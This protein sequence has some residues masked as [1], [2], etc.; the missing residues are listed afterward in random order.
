MSKLTH[1]Q[2]RSLRLRINR[3]AHD[4]T[5]VAYLKERDAL[6]QKV[7]DMHAAGVSY[8]K[9]HSHLDSV[10]ADA[11]KELRSSRSTD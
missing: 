1:E 7:L 6:L 2:S 4:L 3:A 11:A 5:K 9:L 10:E 8:G